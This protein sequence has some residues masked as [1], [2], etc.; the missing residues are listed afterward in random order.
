MKDSFAKR[1]VTPLPQSRIDSTSE[2]SLNV[3]KNL[4]IHAGKINAV[5]LA[6]PMTAKN[7]IF[8]DERA[9]SLTLSMTLKNATL[10][11]QA[12]DFVA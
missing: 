10:L 5:C 11:R 3:K 7:S 9:F 12:H 2:E 6:P 8:R 1:M 4:T